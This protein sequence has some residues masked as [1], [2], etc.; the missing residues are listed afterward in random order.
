M[1]HILIPTDFSDNAFN[2]LQ[3]AFA[4]AQKMGATLTILHVYTEET[5]KEAV[6]QQLASLRHDLV[7]AQ[8]HAVSV[9]I[10]AITG[11]FLSILQEILSQKK[12][13]CVVIGM[14]GKSM[15]EQ[16]F[17]GSNTLNV[18]DNV[19]TPV[20][21]VPQNAVFNPLHKVSLA[22]DT[23]NT[24]HFATFD[25]LKKILLHFKSNLM[26]LT[27]RM[28]QAQ[29]S[30][31]ADKMQLL[32]IKQWIGDQLPVALKT[33]IADSVSEGL[34]YYLAQKSD[35]NLLVMVARKRNFF[36]KIFRTSFTQQMAFVA[37]VPIMIIYEE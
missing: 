25:V 11:D 17:I 37:E 35:N 15:L 5:E 23:H 27:I 19:Q 1:Q 7:A 34:Q 13:Q 14:K 8:P 26:I 36:E 24:Y 10:E 9:F 33:V 31:E 16:I 28:R 12:Y 32:K 18:L 22:I 6:F 29:E 2:A 30:V 3:Y 4:F 20:L 21:V